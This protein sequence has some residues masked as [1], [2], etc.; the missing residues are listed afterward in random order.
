VKRPLLHHRRRQSRSGYVMLIALVLFG[1]LTTV[2]AMTLSMSSADQRVAYHQERYVAARYAA[3]AAVQHGR[4]QLLFNT[5]TEDGWTNPSTGFAPSGALVT[6]AADYRGATDW[7]PSFGP[8][9]P[10]YDAYYRFERCGGA[11]AGY[12]AEMGPN[13]FRT[14]Y[15]RVLGDAS[16]NTAIADNSST[17][18]SRAI[19]SKVTKGA[20][21]VR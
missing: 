14:D 20:C 19:V 13:S 6:I 18:R 5:P 12:S 1:V 4:F 11:P 3:M 2:G 15:W 9:V 8:L 17:A 16:Y 21:Q 7:S 10:N